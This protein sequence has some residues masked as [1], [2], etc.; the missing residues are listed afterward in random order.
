MCKDIIFSF[1]DIKATQAAAFLIKL[2]GQVLPQLFGSPQKCFTSAIAALYKALAI[3]SQGDGFVSMKYG[4]V[5]TKI[6]DYV[7]PKGG[8]ESSDYWSKYIATVSAS[9]KLNKKNRCGSKG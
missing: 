2:H 7:K 9:N 3:R 6:Y 8:F 1:N 4:P 5:L